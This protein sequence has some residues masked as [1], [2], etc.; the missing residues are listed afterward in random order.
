[1]NPKGIK[2]IYDSGEATAD[3]YTVYYC[4]PGHW[5]L[6][7]PDYAYV[8][9]SNNPG[10]PGGVCQHGTGRLGRHNGRRIVFTDLPTAC[11]LVVRRDLED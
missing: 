9:M 10:D 5:G 8:I 6:Q 2:A 7:F 11:Q 1:M 4:W 3:R